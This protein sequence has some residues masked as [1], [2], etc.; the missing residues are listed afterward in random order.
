M[1]Q[2]IPG[3]KVR[4]MHRDISSVTGEE[5]V[6]FTRIASPILRNDKR[7][8]AFLA[9]RSLRSFLGSTASAACWRPCVRDLV[10]S[11]GYAVCAEESQI[12]NGSLWAGPTEDS[13][14]ADY[15]ENSDN[16]NSV[17]AVRFGGKCRMFAVVE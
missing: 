15:S 17:A 16:E 13:K 1:V 6:L 11:D 4:S 2:S 3:I 8:C 7:K 14:K 10:N 5:V 9:L 12:L